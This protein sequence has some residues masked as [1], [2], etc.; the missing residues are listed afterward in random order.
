M[1]RHCCEVRG[2]TARQYS[3]VILH[4]FIWLREHC[5]LKKRL[6]LPPKT[7]TDRHVLQYTQDEQDLCPEYQDV[8]G[9]NHSSGHEY[10]F[11]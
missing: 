5:T 8:R 11:R 10:V 2:T 1:Y 3:T 7:L 4:L 9:E 6:S